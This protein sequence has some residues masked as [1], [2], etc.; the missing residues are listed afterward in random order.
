MSA[1]D[2]P[3]NVVLREA[4]MPKVAITASATPLAAFRARV[5]M[6]VTKVIVGI[7]SVA[8]LAGLVLQVK[9]GVSLQ[10]IS[11]VVAGGTTALTWV[12]ATSLGSVH[13]AEI[14][15]TLEAGEFLCLTANDAKGKVF[16]EY[17]YQVLPA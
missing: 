16:V 5:K 11:S 1:Y 14:N 10:G 7:N 9:H 12:S 6:Y 8:S 2:H 4:I 13:T 15:K 3:E 17:Q